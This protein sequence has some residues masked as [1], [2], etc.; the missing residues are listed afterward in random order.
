MMA[1]AQR[2]PINSTARWYL[3]QTGGRDS[4]MEKNIPEGEA[5]DLW[6]SQ[7]MAF[8]ATGTLNRTAFGLTW[9]KALETGGV[10]VGEDVKLSLEVQ[11]VEAQVPAAV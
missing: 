6:G 3:V 9:N 2:R 8:T 1:P 5:Q 7:R 10:L 4:C 11:L